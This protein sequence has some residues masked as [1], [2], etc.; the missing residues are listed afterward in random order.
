MVLSTVWFSERF[1][2]L[3]PLLLC[4]GTKPSFPW[5]TAEGLAAFRSLEAAFLLSHSERLLL[6]S[7]HSPPA[8]WDEKKESW[9]NLTPLNI[10]E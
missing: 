6:K 10:R 9:E 2:K 3:T 7:V 4:R 5:N 8:L 1:P